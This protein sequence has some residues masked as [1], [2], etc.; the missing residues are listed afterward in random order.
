MLKTKTIILFIAST[1]IGCATGG[2]TKYGPMTD[3][4]G[5]DDKKLD[6]NRFVTRFAA[7]ANTHES[8]AQAFV[9]F[10]AIEVCNHNGFNL[11]DVLDSKDLSSSKT[12]Q[13]T[14]NYNY[15][16]PTYFNGNAYSN[17]NYNYY[18]G[19]YGSSNNNTNLYGTMSGGGGYGGSRSW[20]ETY[21]Y[22]TYDLL[23]TCINQK[24]RIGIQVKEISSDEMKPFVKDFLGALL[25][26]EVEDSSPNFGI[27][28][29][30]DI[31][32]RVNGARVQNRSDLVSGINFVKNKIQM[33][34][35]RD[36]KKIFLNAKTF[37]GTQELQAKINKVI[38]SACSQVPEVK[39]RPLCTVRTPASK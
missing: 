20:Q 6:N 5:Y 16:Q 18:G 17:T 22:P 27:V 25:V 2:R 31:I 30:G 1:L 33:V 4:G 3:S 15:Q 37:D 29:K 14:S 10:R 11:V 34:V 26:E 39:N 7:N 24:I 32:L 12:V 38:S 13:R 36:G 9:M 28:Q 21:H 19:G 8:Y 35:M 23:Y